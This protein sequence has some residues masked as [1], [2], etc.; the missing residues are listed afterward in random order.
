MALWSAASREGLRRAV[1]VEGLRK[2]SEWTAR[3]RGA[4]EEWPAEPHDPFFNV[5]TVEDLAEAEKLA[6]IDD[7]L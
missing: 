7:R 4:T 3:F 6:L 2:V 5:N 1:A